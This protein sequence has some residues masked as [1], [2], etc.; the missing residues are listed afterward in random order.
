MARIYKATAASREPR[1]SFRPNRPAGL[2]D[3]C[4]PQGCVRRAAVSWPSDCNTQEIMSVSGHSSLKEVERYIRDFDRKKAAARAQA[5]VTAA[6]N[7]VPLA[8]VR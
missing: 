1:H 2:P 8:I 4:V 5:K 6:G 3:T 7:V